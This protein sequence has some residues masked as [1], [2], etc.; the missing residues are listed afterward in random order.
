[1][2]DEPTTGLDL[3]AERGLMDLIVRLNRERGLTVVFVGHDL[4]QVAS[5]ASH[6]AIVANGRVA[7]GPVAEVFTGPALS[8]AFGV[9]I[10]IPDAGRRTQDAP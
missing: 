3:V 9:E 6:V 7:S 1:V 5:H 4:G 2:V 10:A 8:A